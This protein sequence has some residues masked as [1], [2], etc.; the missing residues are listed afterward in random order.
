MEGDRS[1]PALRG[2][3]P[4]AFAHVFAHIGQAQGGTRFLVRCSYLEIYCEEVRDLLGADQKANLPVKEHPEIGVYVK[5][6]TSFVVKSADELDKIMTKGN[7]G[8][9]LLAVSSP[10]AARG[11]STAGFPRGGWQARSA[12]RR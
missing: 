4:N 2:I 8:R 6:L 10:S 9:A 5:G 7:L 11:G 1:V 3:M 12:R